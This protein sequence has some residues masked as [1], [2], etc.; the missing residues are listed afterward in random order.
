MT[1]TETLNL[2]LV[3]RGDGTNY[4]ETVA[5]VAAAHEED[6][7]RGLGTHADGDQH[8]S[9]WWASTTTVQLIGQA[10]PQTGAGIVIAD[11]HAG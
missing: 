3:T 4:D 2:Y 9:I 6:G 1:T 5:Y 7:A 10:A 8:D 11:F